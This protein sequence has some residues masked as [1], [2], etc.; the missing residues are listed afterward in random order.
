M[1]GCM[2]H[3]MLS[4]VIFSRIRLPMLSFG[5][6]ATCSFCLVL[7]TSV[8]LCNGALAPLLLWVQNLLKMAGAVNSKPL[9]G[10][11]GAPG[12]PMPTKNNLLAPNAQYS[13]QAAEAAKE[14]AI[15]AAK[16]A[17]KAAAEAAIEA[18]ALPQA[19][20]IPQPETAVPLIAQPMIPVAVDV[21]MQPVATT[22]QPVAAT[23]PTAVPPAAAAVPAAVAAV[24]PTAVPIAVPMPVPVPTAAVPPVAAPEQPAVPVPVAA[25]EAAVPQA[26]VLAYVEDVDMDDDGPQLIPPPT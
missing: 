18:A 24:V 7:C 2:L 22:F 6:P 14:A 26:E 20:F 1:L 16:E 11:H 8:L 19:M 15:E 5:L 9:P 21:E 23:I 10:I 12:L 13:R 17:A 25:G 3:H 4:P